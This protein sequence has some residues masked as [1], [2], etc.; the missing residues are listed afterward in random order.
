MTYIL[1]RYNSYTYGP[2]KS[3]KLTQK[4][5]YKLI[6]LKDDDIAI[7][8][9]YTYKDLSTPINVKA[10]DSFAGNIENKDIK[11]DDN[12]FIC[13]C[14]CKNCNCNLYNSST[15]GKF[16]CI[17]EQVVNDDEYLK[18]GLYEVEIHDQEKCTLKKDL[19]KT[20]NTDKL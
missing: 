18:S 3:S 17:S 6:D 5:V 1:V 19:S 15:N 2:F 20:N 9:K 14:Q 10:L 12:I 16:S 4:D 11:I 8:K 13:R 7:M